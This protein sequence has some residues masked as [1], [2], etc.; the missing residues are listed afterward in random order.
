MRN[1]INHRR[2]N[3]S[4]SNTTVNAANVPS[5]LLPAATNANGV[6]IRLLAH[7]SVTASTLSR[8]AILAKATAPANITDG[9]ILAMPT[10]LNVNGG[11]FFLM[12][13]NP[14]IFVPAGLGIWSICDQPETA[15]SCLRAILAEVL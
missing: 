1:L 6:I 2:Y 8:L 10:L 9:I 3:F 12:N 15:A 11:T 13:E 14:D 5:E 4:A 7:K